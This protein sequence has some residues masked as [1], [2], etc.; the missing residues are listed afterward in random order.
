MLRLVLGGVVWCLFAVSWNR[1]RQ[2][3]ESTLMDHSLYVTGLV[4][5]AP[6]RTHVGEGLIVVVA[7]LLVAVIIWSGMP[8]GDGRGVLFAAII[9]VLSMKTI[10]N[11][12]VMKSGRWL[13]ASKRRRRA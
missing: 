4:S 11:A 6:N 7:G 3:A 8:S 12:G 2:R 1:A 10:E 9:V 5:A 13:A